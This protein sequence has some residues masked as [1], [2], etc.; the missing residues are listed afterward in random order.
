MR[1]T[2]WGAASAVADF[3]GVLVPDGVG[4]GVQVGDVVGGAEPAGCVEVEAFADACGAGA[5]AGWE[6]GHEFEFGGEDVA[7]AEL[8]AG[9]GRPDR[10]G[11]CFGCGEAG[12]AGAVAAEEAV[13]AVGSAVGVDGDVRRR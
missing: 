10:G 2:C 3:D 1:V 8:V 13:A 12:E 4:D 5:E 11:F 7:E 9:P 6:G